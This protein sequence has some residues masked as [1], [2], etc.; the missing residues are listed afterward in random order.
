MWERFSEKTPPRSE[1]RDLSHR[2]KEKSWSWEREA[3]KCNDI[4]LAPLHLM[5]AT[6]RVPL[7]MCLDAPEWNSHPP[8]GSL[9]R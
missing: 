7:A 6:G 1:D 2:A 3:W 9:E 5:L 8:G 4:L